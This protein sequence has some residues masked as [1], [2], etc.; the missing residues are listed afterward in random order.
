MVVN[1]VSCNLTICDNYAARDIS[2]TQVVQRDTRGT[3]LRTGECEISILT[4]VV[5]LGINSNV[6]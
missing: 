5:I 6:V 1:Q 4:P 3:S 2:H